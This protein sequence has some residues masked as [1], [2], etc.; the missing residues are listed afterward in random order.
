MKKLFILFLFTSIFTNLQAQLNMELASKTTYAEDLNDVWGWSNPDDGREYAI[1]GLRNGVS[2]VDVTDPQNPKERGF[3]SG[4]RSTWRDMKTFNGWAYIVHDIVDNNRAGAGL[5]SVDLTGL[6][7][8]ITSDDFFYTEPQFTS[9]VGTETIT[10]C[11]NIYIDEFGIAYLAGCDANAGGNIFMDVTEPGQPQMI[12]PGPSIYAHD[13][14]TRDNL[15]YSSEINAG[16]MG[17]YDVSDKTNVK[18]LGFQRT[19]FAFTHNVWLS[20]DGKTAYTTD[21]K[22]NAPVAAY[23]VSDPTDIQELDRFR[24]ALS[25]GDGVFPHNVHVWNDYLI[26]SYY[27]DGCIIADASRPNNLVEVGNFDTWLGADNGTDGMWGAYPF[28]PSGNILGA[29][30]DNGFYVFVPTYVRACHLE[31][32]ITDETFGSPLKD[33]TVSISTTDNVLNE[34]SKI[35]GAYAIGQVTPGSF[36][37]TFSKDGFTSQ[38][39]TVELVNGE[40]VILDIV[41]KA[42]VPTYQVDVS[43][44]D[45]SNGAVIPNANIVFVNNRDQNN[46]NADANGDFSVAALFAGDYSIYAGEWGYR[47]KEVNFS[48]SADTDLTIELEQGYYD[49]FLF[50][51]DWTVQELASTGNWIKTDPVGTF[52]GTETVN[53]FDDLLDDLG[54]ECYVTGNGGERPW[55]DDVDNGTTILTSPI[56]DLTGYTNPTLT[57]HTWF[58]NSAGNT[59]LNDTLIVTVSNGI[60]EVV[61]EKVSESAGAWKPAVFFELSSLITITDNMQ[62]RYTASDLPGSGNIVEA[63]VDGFEIFSS[64]PVST[65]ELD[66]NIQLMAFPN[67]FDQ[68]IT[69]SYQ[70]SNKVKNGVLEVYDLL[71]RIR[72]LVPVN[73]NVGQAVFGQQLNPGI[74]FVR[75]KV[76][77]VVSEPLRI[78]KN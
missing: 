60:E 15:M 1:I 2:I 52:E 50:D 61:V 65:E 3:I 38:T 37:V 73:E 5:L 8:T 45:A 19:P 42:E 35:D 46:F 48:L 22:S 54:V 17:V 25:F 16:R 68:Q 4:P 23:D 41:M 40:L 39:H 11:H 51:Y 43:V 21:E 69:L 28:L 14:Y 33:V 66:A 76:D 44:V 70:L 7:D 55:T 26:I 67:P 74:Y 47:T 64:L 57:Y 71:G 10:R 20:D 24:P 30:I 9:A 32:T 62:I 6:P 63:G 59:P 78:V 49:D 29:D 13:V 53:P 72:E 18:A 34:R 75:L 31:G 36:E 77:D 27:A 12:G 58:W 56:M